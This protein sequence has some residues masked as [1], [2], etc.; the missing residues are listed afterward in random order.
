MA[1]LSLSRIGDVGVSVTKHRTLNVLKGVISEEQLLDCSDTE[2]QEGLKDE[3]V[4]AA[5]RIVMRRDGREIPTKHVVLSFQLH[6]LPSTVKAG[7]INCHVQ[8]FVPNPRRCF[9]CQRFGHGSQACRGKTTCPKC[10]GTEQDHVVEACQK[11]LHCANCKGN[12]PAYSRSCPRW[13][14][15]K[16]ILRIKVTQDISYK[17]AKTQ[18][19][20]ANKG[21]YAAVAR[22][23]V[24][25]LTKSVETQTSEPLPH[26]PQTKEKPVESSSPVAPAASVGHQQA[27][28]ASKEV[29]GAPSVWD[30]VPRDSSQTTNLSMEVDDDDCSSQKSTSSLPNS[31]SEM[32]EQRQRRTGRGRGCNSKEK[33]KQ[34]PPRVQPP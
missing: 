19:E 15:E 21:G 1:L 9:K 7:Y 30:G 10:A 26:T 16:D 11:E 4:T 31:S 29:V 5:R 32:K 3:G 14:E 23:G 33:A 13:K 2:I 28:T 25:P 24:V 27:A 18:Y 34:P 6:R 17:D 22:R 12:H 20:F 8:P